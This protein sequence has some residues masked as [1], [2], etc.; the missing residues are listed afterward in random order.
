M[1]EVDIQHI[2]EDILKLQRDISVI[3]HILSEEGELTEWAKEALKK[4]REEPESEYTDL[5]DI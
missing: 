4:A 2:H 3:K 1:T 5:N